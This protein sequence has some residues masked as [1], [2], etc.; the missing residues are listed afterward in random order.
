MWASL[1]GQSS[2]F[3]SGKN[4]AA[5]WIGWVV[6]LSARNGSEEDGKHR[7]LTGLAAWGEVATIN[8]EKLLLTTLP[9][10]LAFY[11]WVLSNVWLSIHFKYRS[12]ACISSVIFVTYDE[13][14][15]EEAR[16]GRHS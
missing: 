8:R 15:Q 16:V 7:S 14:K 6:G 12:P 4:A 5:H 13:L 3:T 1:G 11:S 2:C 9:L 10:Q